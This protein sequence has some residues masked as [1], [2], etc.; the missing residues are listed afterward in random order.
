MCTYCTDINNTKNIVNTIIYIQYQTISIHYIYE[1]M[2]A[3]KIIIYMYVLL[4][5][6]RQRNTRTLPT[7]HGPTCAK[8]QGHHGSSQQFQ[9]QPHGS[10]ASG[11]VLHVW[12]WLSAVGWDSLSELDWKASGIV[13]FDGFVYTLYIIKVMHDN[14]IN[15]CKYLNAINNQTNTLFVDCFAEMR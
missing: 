3:C 7:N 6:M 8:H 1:Y 2:H 10:N 12:S 5:S 9:R 13:P 15:I 11:S 4:A 14:S